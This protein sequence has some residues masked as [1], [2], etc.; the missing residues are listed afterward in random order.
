MLEIIQ[1]CLTENDILMLSASHFQVSA[2]HGRSGRKWELKSRTPRTGSPDFQTSTLIVVITLTSQTFEHTPK[3]YFLKLYLTLYLPMHK[4]WV[5]LTPT[6]F[7]QQ[8]TLKEMRLKHGY[9]FLQAFISWQ[10]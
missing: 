1:L 3:Y 2:L 6:N 7:I 5:N 8:G 4:S 9:Y 10:F